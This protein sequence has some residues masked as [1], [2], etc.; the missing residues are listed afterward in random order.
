MAIPP[1]LRPRTRRR[2]FIPPYLLD[3]VVLVTD[4]SESGLLAGDAGALVH[5]YNECGAYEVEFVALDG[6]IAAVVTGRRVAFIGG[7]R[8][9]RGGRCR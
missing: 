8:R 2:D 5:V 4:L 7:G 1:S 6:T 9:R 3:R